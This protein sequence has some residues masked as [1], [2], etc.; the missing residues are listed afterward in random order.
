MGGG[1]VCGKR[2]RASY[3]GTG[4]APLS[5]RAPSARWATQGVHERHLLDV[6]RVSECRVA[7]AGGCVVIV[8]HVVLVD[9]G[10]LHVVDVAEDH[11]HDTKTTPDTTTYNINVVSIHSLSIS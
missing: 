9:V 2:G 3:V 6:V 1:V 11:T 5:L 8:T 10:A 4:D 7:G